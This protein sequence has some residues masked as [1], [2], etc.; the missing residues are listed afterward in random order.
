MF[1]IFIWASNLR[2][3]EHLV[4]I[5]REFYMKKAAAIRDCMTKL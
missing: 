5:F 2:H 4:A 3:F 1:S